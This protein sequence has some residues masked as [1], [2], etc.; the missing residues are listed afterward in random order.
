MEFWKKNIGGT[1]GEISWLIFFFKSRNISGGI[2]GKLEIL[3]EISGEIVKEIPGKI[4]EHVPR[5]NSRESA[6]DTLGRTSYEIL[7]GISGKRIS[8][9]LG[10]FL[11]EIL[12]TSMWEFVEDFVKIFMLEFLKEFIKKVVS[13]FPRAIFQKIPWSNFFRNC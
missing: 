2:I 11:L 1:P 3:R 9:H 8:K 7:V 4:F 12:K 6:G 5:E 10:K 13:E